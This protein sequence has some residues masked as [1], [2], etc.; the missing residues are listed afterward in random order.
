MGK[1]TVVSITHLYLIRHGESEGNRVRAFLGHTDLDLSPLGY[2][3]AE[4]TAE[5][6]S[7]IPV[8]AIYAS[9]L[10]RAYHTAVPTAKKKGMP[11]VK[12]EELREIRAGL[13]EAVPFDELVTCHPESYA[14]W[15]Q[16]FGR[17]RCDE[18]ES[19]L[20]LQTRALAEVTRIAEAH[21]DGTVFLFTHAAP[22]RVLAGAFEGKS[23]DEMKDVPWASNA[24]VTHVVYRDGAFE[25]LEYSHDEHLKELVTVLPKNV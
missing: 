10:L 20:E 16:N 5:Y 2:R 11:I 9:D 23:V 19:V 21:P 22:I 13:W 25:I 4:K 1:E 18:G 8:D 24:S 12:S 14:L 6:L 17:A 3:Q 15:L 7:E